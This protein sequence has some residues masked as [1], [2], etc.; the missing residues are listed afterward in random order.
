MVRPRLEL[1][2]RNGVSWRLIGFCIAWCSALSVI[3]LPIPSTN[4]I[5][6]LAILFL[7]VGM[8]KFDR[9]LICFGYVTVVL[10]TVLFAALGSIIWEV[11]GS[12]TKLFH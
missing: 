5:P 6:A 9:I 10:T 7:A 1:L 2:A 3:P 4:K 11:L 12:W 8:V